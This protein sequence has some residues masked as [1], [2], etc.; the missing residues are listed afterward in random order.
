MTQDAFQERLARLQGRQAEQREQKQ[1]EAKAQFALPPGQR[2]SRRDTVLLARAALNREG[3][4]D[5]HSYPALLRGL[6][7]L[8]LWVKPLHY[9]NTVGLLAYMMILFVVLFAGSALVCVL[10]G[11]VP[12]YIYRMI[13]MGVVGLVYIPAGLGAAAALYIK[14]QAWSASLPSWRELRGA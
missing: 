14:V 5:S 10:I 13:E 7:R 9:W 2:R 4:R 8:G 1:A 12:R 11:F 3:I 6:S